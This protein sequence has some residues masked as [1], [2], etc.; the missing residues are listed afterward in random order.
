MSSS[1]AA[2]GQGQSASNGTGLGPQVAHLPCS[3]RSGLPPWDG[4]WTLASASLGELIHPASALWEDESGDA[5]RLEGTGPSCQMPR[6]PAEMRPGSHGAGLD[7]DHAGTTHRARTQMHQ[8]PV[9]GES[10]LRA[11]HA[12]RRDA[13][14]IAEGDIA[15][16]EGIEQPGM[17]ACC[18]SGRRI[19]CWRLT[20]ADRG[21]RGSVLPCLPSQTTCQRSLWGWRGQACP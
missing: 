2:R 6:S 1:S 10:V 9:V 11:V 12:H 21:D 19:Q 17:Q 15:D 4:A 13:D 5:R 16:L 8:V 20:W 7:A 3:G 14:A 18:A